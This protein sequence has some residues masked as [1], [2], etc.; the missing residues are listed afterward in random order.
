MQPVS[1]RPS[2][3]GIRVQHSSPSPGAHSARLSQG[4]DMLGNM[5]YMNSDWA[6]NGAL[7]S[8]VNFHRNT[9]GSASRHHKRASSGSSIASN[10]PPS[11]LDSTILYPHIAASDTSDFSPA[12]YDSFENMFATQQH[13]QTPKSL[14]TPVNTPTQNSFLPS[15]YQ[16]YGFSSHEIQELMSSMKRSRQDIPDDD[17]G[18][19]SYSQGHPSVSSVSRNSPATPQTNYDGD[20][21]EQKMMMNTGKDSRDTHWRTDI[22]L[23]S[24][25]TAAFGHQMP[26]MQMY[27]DSNYGSMQNSPAPTNKKVSNRPAPLNTQ[28]RKMISDRLQAASQD[29]LR[30]RTQSPAT[31]SPRD[32]SPFRQSSP[33]MDSSVAQAQFNQAMSLQGGAAGGPMMMAPQQQN[34]QTTETPKTISPKDTVLE[35]HEEDSASSLF[36]EQTNNL[37]F[38]P[39]R[40]SSSF[41]NSGFSSNSQF[42]SNAYSTPTGI[43]QQYPGFISQQSRTTSNLQSLS[44]QTPDFRPTLTSMESTV[45][46]QSQE[47]LT[48]SPQQS[49]RP[50]DTK[51][52][53]G[54]YTC[55]YHGCTHRFETQAKLQKHKREAHRQ[56]SPTA[57]PTLLRNSQAGPHKCERIN[58]TTGKPCNSIFSRPY[59]LTRHE[60]TIHNARKQKVRCHLCTEEKTFSRNDALTRHMRLVHPDVDWPGKTSR[61]R[62]GRD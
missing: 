29:H 46:D 62:G 50:Q 34:A 10:G 59:D 28:Y 25:S 48:S 52:D 12:Q 57:S 60:D 20:F 18:S 13:S 30:A 22:Y 17:A 19:Y 15:E 16:T 1:P 53:G 24:D 44:E 9:P 4:H 39:R 38:Q 51:S 41:S 49:R 45:S 61:R 5:Q 11:P 32:R 31:L 6:S 35:Y 42:Y 8:P 43:P 14:P 56:T 33:W 58:P 27:P 40:E 54:T 7:L 21:E 47:P 23:Q 2:Q 55:T 36:P 3:P 26:N 37:Q